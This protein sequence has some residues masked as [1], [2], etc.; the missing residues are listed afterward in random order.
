VRVGVVA[1][2]RPVKN[3]DGL[4]RVAASLHD[5]LPGLQFEVAGEGEQRPELEKLIAE[6]RL[7][8]RFRLLGSVSDIPAFLGRQ[9]IAILPSH[10]EGMSN[11]LLEYMASGRMIITTNV[12]AAGS[13]I[14][15]RIHGQLV[16]AGDD[17]A[18]AAAIAWSVQNPEAGRTMAAA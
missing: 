10:S 14:Q 18:L 7:T 5:T 13:L 11:A 16:P 2:L 3:I 4:I 9:D 1:N 12:G 15:D 17:A 8:E 6:H